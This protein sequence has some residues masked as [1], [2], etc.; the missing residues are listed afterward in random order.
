MSFRMLKYI[1]AI[2]TRYLKKHPKAKTLPL[3]FPLVFYNGQEK[4]SVPLSIYDLFDSA[5]LAKDYLAS[6]KLIDVTKVD[7]ELKAKHNF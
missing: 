1:I 7:D 6:Y 3:I 2:C 5:D 4:Y